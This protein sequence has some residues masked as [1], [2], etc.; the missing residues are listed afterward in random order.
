MAKYIDK[1]LLS[2]ERRAIISLIE[3]NKDSL[4]LAGISRALGRN[5]AYF[6]QYLYRQSPRLLPEK[7]RFILARLLGVQQSDLLA[8]E[9]R[10]HADI[11][12]VA[13][14]FLEVE[15][16]AGA[17][18][19][20]DVTQETGPAKWYFADAVF[21]Q[22]S[23]TGRDNLRLVTVRGTSMSPDLEDGDTILIDLGQIHPRPSGIFVLDDGHGLVVKRLEFVPHEEEPRVRIISSNPAF[24]PY[25]RKFSDIRIIGR[26][27][28]MA[29]PLR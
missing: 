3:N 22:L 10:L 23:H 4:S 19:H 6:H 18:S 11:G 9:Q 15:T 16:A 14:P 25:R 7:E 27:I 5:D 29:R 24:V 12:Q 28:W 17:A 8:D 26:V 1:S 21:H 20:I 2:S 13:I